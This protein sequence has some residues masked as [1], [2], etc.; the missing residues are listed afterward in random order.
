MTMPD[1][2]EK[3]GKP[4]VVS[5]GNLS[6]SAKFASA[7]AERGR[8]VLTCI[9]GGSVDRRVEA[10]V[11]GI[12]I[13]SSGDLIWADKGAA[14][15]IN[16]GSFPH[17]ALPCRVRFA[18]GAGETDI[19]PPALIRSAADAERLV[20]PGRLENVHIE[21]SNGVIAGEGINRVNGVGKPLLLARVNGELLREVRPGEPRAR[22]EG[23]SA[24]SFTVAIEPA[25][26][27]GTGAH[28]EILALPDMT[29]L[30]ALSFPRADFN[31][32]T[33]AITRNEASIQNLSRRLHL[34]LVR[35]AELAERRHTEQRQILDATIEYLIALVY[36]RFAGGNNARAAAE[37]QG[38][39]KQFRKAVDE[40]V[41]GGALDVAG[42]SA[43]RPD[44]AC[45]A[46]GW[47]W[48]EQDT[49]GFDFRW[50]GLGGV[51]FN[52]QPE[53]PVSHITVS[54]GKTY[55]GLEPDFSA[56]LD[57]D[58][59][60]VEVVHSPSGAPY[61]L[62][63]LPRPTGQARLVEVLRLSSATA[64]R[65]A[66]DEGTDDQRVLSAA[67]SGAVFYYGT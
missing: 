49:K 1:M 35:A 14:A 44:S 26:L 13:G 62:K 7:R 23:G 43:V 5:P 60:D 37:Q 55:R 4:S 42:Y 28:Y 63:V 59:A 16:C 45:F 56:L 20:G 50:M 66:E 25:D 34:E 22:D 12:R 36:D 8:F 39:F 64:G 57:A 30:A 54:I 2:S 48:V 10:F 51:I 27:T 3:V 19:A 31:A 40:A 58:A 38:V 15:V 32:L 33:V 24:V 46:D 17:V 6:S 29:V 61:T 47:S 11:D 18:A 67:V 9:A 53:R 52:P 65:P 41:S 21:V